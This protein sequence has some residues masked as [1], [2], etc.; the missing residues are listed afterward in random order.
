MA[1]AS[2]SHGVGGGAKI[3]D[4]WR[5][6]AVFAAITEGTR[7]RS[8][9]RAARAITTRCA[10]DGPVAGGHGQ[11]SRFGDCGPVTG[12]PDTVTRIP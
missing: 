2:A 5:F 11:R 3:A 10:S 4:F 9:G 6:S 1:L 12:E 7:Q 8:T